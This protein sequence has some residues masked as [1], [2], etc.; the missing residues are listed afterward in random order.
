MV[1][2]I[3]FIISLLAAV[4]NY[5]AAPLLFWLSVATAVIILVSGYASSYIIARPKIKEHKQSVLQMKQNRATNEEIEEF[6]KC[7]KES[8]EFDYKAVPTWIS[9]INLLAIVAGLILFILGII[10][11]VGS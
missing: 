11:K 5:G 9:I 10:N 3:G 7:P 2:K 4:V 6:M 1:G 8:V